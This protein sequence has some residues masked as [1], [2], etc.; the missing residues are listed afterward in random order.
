MEFRLMSSAFCLAFSMMIFIPRTLA[1]MS[2]ILWSNLISPYFKWNLFWSRFPE[3]K[4]WFWEY[5][6]ILPA[7]SAMKLLLLCE[8]SVTSSPLSSS[9]VFIKLSITKILVA[10]VHLF[11]VVCQC[12][13]ECNF[14]LIG[15]ES[16]NNMGNKVNFVS[17]SRQV[18]FGHFIIWGDDVVC[19]DQVRRESCDVWHCLCVTVMK[20]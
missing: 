16:E 6:R 18:D 11:N 14:T 8:L 13:R 17:R 15:K 9:Q 4:I 10:I 20:D 3:S 7:E 5:L 1:S 19:W 2:A 12:H